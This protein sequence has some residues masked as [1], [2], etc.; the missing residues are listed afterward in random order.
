MY[1][2]IF[3]FL[4]IT[5]FSSTSY[6][7][8]TDILTSYRING[9]QNIA[10]KLD[11][12]LAKPEYWRE[13]L[14][15]KNTQFG[16]IES[17]SNI[18]VCNKAQSKLS[19]YV[20]DANNTYTLERHY[21]AFTG[22]EKGDK[23][24]EGDLRTPNGIY[25]LTKKIQKLDSFYGPLAFVTSYPNL[26]DK[27]KGKTGKG[28]WIHGLP[29]NQE[30]DA[31]TKG[32]IAINN[33]GLKCLDKDINITKTLLIID[34]KKVKTNISKKTLANILAQLYKWR[35]AWIYNDLDSYLNFYSENF[36]RFD[37]MDIGRFS[38]YKKRIFA[39]NESK[40]ILFNNI[41]IL[42]YPNEHLTYKIT[43]KERYKSNSFSFTGDKILIVKLTPQNKITIITE[44]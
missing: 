42:P 30:R 8:E 28:I 10:Q 14:K 4:M 41:N 6:A 35:Y 31:F 44:Q 12:A 20:K 32:C 5:L 23:Q 24:Y 11:N 17:Y 15:D 16:Y 1:N 38:K 43:F 39:K 19:L 3:I 34:E 33:K 27:Y 26:Y 2:K 21:S 29:I 25:N 18:L 13:Y 7:L 9:I 37:G 40:T 22:K 36:K